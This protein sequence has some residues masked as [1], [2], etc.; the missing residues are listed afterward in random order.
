M[1]AHWGI[2]NLVVVDGEDLTRQIVFAIGFRE[3][4]NRISIFVNL[5]LDKLR[6]Q[7]K[8]DEIGQIRLADTKEPAA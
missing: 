1:T 4:Q 6:L 8:V 2:E 3:L 7:E 5:P